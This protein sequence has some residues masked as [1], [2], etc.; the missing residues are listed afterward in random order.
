M[1]SSFLAQMRRKL[2]NSRYTGGREL[3][4]WRQDMN[5]MVANAKQYHPSRPPSYQRTMLRSDRNIQTWLI[6]IQ[7]FAAMI[8]ESIV[9]TS[10]SRI[11][12]RAD[13]RGV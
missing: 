13:S 8:L 6:R 12:H 2:E 7:G 3:T 11:L 5:L 1:L 4:E 9:D 10:P